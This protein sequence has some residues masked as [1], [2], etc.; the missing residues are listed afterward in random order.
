VSAEQETGFTMTIGS[1]LDSAVA[2]MQAARDADLAAREQEQQ[3]AAKK[4]ITRAVG[5]VA[6]ELG[7]DAPAVTNVRRQKVYEYHRA[8][9]PVSMFVADVDD[10]LVGATSP[11]EGT[12]TIWLVRPCE[13]CGLLIRVPTSPQ[14]WI[15]ARSITRHVAAARCG[16]PF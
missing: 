6:S 16:E 8:T 2:A 7:I 9:D 15:S 12:T 4:A 1:A 13:H 14:G 11:D 5:V 10:I 3:A